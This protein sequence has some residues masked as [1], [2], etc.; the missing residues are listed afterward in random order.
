[1]LKES[2]GVTAPYK[3]TVHHPLLISEHVYY[4]SASQGKNEHK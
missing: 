1:M 2:T 4:L 3:H